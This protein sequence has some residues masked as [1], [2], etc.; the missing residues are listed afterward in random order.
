MEEITIKWQR[1]EFFYTIFFFFFME[2][3]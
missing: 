3:L 2:V 1:V